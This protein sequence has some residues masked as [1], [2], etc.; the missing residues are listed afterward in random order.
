MQVAY[1]YHY[2]VNIQ[3][4]AILTLLKPSY[5]SYR[6]GLAAQSCSIIRL[7]S[8]HFVRGAIHSGIVLGR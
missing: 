7:V 5:S 4:N 3:R 1:S 6:K 2:Q 8:T